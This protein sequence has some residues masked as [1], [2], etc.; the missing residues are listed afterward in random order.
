MTTLRRIRGFYLIY[1]EGSSLPEDFGGPKKRA[2]LLS[3]SVRAENR[4]AALTESLRTGGALFPPQMYL[5]SEEELRAELERER[6]EA[7]MRLLLAA[8]PGS[9]QK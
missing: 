6:E 1:P 4:P 2:A 7:E 5:P 9:Q 8:E 3:E